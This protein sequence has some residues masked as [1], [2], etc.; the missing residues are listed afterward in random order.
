MIR[1]TVRKNRRVAAL[2]AMAASAG[3]VILACETPTPPNTDQP[4][5]TLESEAVPAEVSAAEDGYFLVKKAAGDVEYVGPVS[6]DQLKLIREETGG[7]PGK[8]FIVREV[9]KEGPLAEIQEGD[10]AG[11]VI[12]IR[13]NTGDGD[14]PPDPNR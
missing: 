6:E 13:E 10:E 1:S 2:V 14:E 11:R 7:D 5:Q 12:R 8:A 4:D 9:S 3:F